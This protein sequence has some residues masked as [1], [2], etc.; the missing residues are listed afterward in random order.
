MVDP[1][2]KFR[3]GF[4]KVVKQAGDIA[5]IPGIEVRGKLGTARRDPSEVRSEG[6]LGMGLEVHRVVE[7]FAS[8]HRCEG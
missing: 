3:F 2:L 6:L 8:L 7:T 1:F 5:L 4:A